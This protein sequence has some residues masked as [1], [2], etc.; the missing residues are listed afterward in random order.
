MQHLIDKLGVERAG[1]LVVEH[2][3][4]LH[5]KR[6]GEGGALLLAAGEVGWVA[7][8]V[9]AEADFLEKRAAGFLGILVG[10]APDDDRSHHGV[11]QKRAV[12][13]KIELLEHHADALAEGV[14]CLLEIGIQLCA[15]LS[16]NGRPGRGDD[17]RI[18]GLESVD[19][20]EHR[21]F[22]T[23]RGADDRD[24]I[25][26]L[27]REAHAFENRRVIVA[28]VQILNRDEWREGVHRWVAVLGWTALEN[29]GQNVTNLCWD[30]QGVDRRFCYI[31][32]IA[33][34]PA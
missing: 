1:R 13:E 5:G 28:F 10:D 29:K 26:L 11:L 9:S 8:G 25:A 20:S 2:D 7:V 12:G 27:D 31:E 24:Q 19:A 16:G 34:F 21:A 32:F 18:Q 14:G 22:A 23:S 3:F 6:A 33:A 30:T 4:R 15:G 17:A